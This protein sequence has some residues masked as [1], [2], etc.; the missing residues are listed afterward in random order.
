MRSHLGETYEGT[1]SA[2][3]GSGAFVA[4]DAPYV[5]VLVRYESM[6]NEP[7]E[8]DE[9]G[10]TA[11]GQRSG[12]VIRLGDRMSV[13]VDDVSIERRTVFGTRLA[14]LVEQNDDR[15]QRTRARGKGH[16]DV[17]D[18]KL[19]QRRARARA[20]DNRKKPGKS[21]AKKSPS[22]KGSSK[23]KRRR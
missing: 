7:Y 1:V 20:E 18:K 4:I 11:V 21:P 12:D 3:V 16:G 17:R 15:P 8:L 10:L 19:A 13:R 22:R 23:G 5:D 2:L 6:G 14:S 9:E